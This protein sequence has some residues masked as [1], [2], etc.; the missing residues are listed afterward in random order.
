MRLA[1]FASSDM[2]DRRCRNDGDGPSWVLPDVHGNL[3]IRFREIGDE[4]L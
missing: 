2:D 1:T 3:G 4:D